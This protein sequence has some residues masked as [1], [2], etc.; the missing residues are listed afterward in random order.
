[1]YKKS[2]SLHYEITKKIFVN[3]ENK[4]SDEYEKPSV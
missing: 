3:L 1:M 2:G 4:K